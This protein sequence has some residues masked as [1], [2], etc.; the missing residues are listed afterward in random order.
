M[1]SLLVA[2]V[3]LHAST[4]V[5]LNVQ[6]LAVISGLIVPLITAIVTKDVASRAI[7]AWCTA[8]LSAV[9]G[10][11]AVAT[12]TAGHIV[13]GQ[14]VDGIFMSFFTAIATYYGFWKPTGTAPAISS[15]TASFGIGSGSSS[16]S[17]DTSVTTT[18]SADQTNPAEQLAEVEAKQAESEHLNT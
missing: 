18:P 17:G 6:A 14:W 2:T 5:Q 10:G 8:I 13:I 3:A 12:Q 9:A 1:L 7:R 16:N 11:I 15:A 4:V